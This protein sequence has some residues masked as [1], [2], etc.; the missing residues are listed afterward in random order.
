MLRLG[1]GTLLPLMGTW[2]PNPWLLSKKPPLVVP[3]SENTMSRTDAS[4]GTCTWACRNPTPP[5]TTGFSS[6]GPIW[7]WCAPLQCVNYTEIHCVTL[8][9]KPCAVTVDC[10]HLTFEDKATA[11]GYV[12]A[13]VS[14]GV[15]AD[16]STEV[17]TGVSIWLS[18]CLV[19]QHKTL[20]SLC[21]PTLQQGSHDEHSCQVLHFSCGQIS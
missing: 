19:L 13:V 12:F 18:C 17:S 14:T 5:G 3:V 8:G 16:M 21:T 6:R 1:W 11:G 10:P 2:Y 20:H 9:S 7:A 4:S 15:S